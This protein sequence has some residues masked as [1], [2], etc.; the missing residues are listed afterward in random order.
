MLSD[1][2]KHHKNCY[3][4]ILNLLSID[5]GWHMSTSALKKKKR[6]KTIIFQP[7]YTCKIAHLACSPILD[8]LMNYTDHFLPI[9]WNTFLE[10]IF[11]GPRSQSVDQTG[12]ELAISF[13]LTSS[14]PLS[15]LSL[16]SGG[17]PGVCH[18][19]AGVNNVYASSACPVV[20]TAISFFA[21]F[22]INE[23]VRSLSDPFSH[24]SLAGPAEAPCHF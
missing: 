12:L 2:L 5:Q 21:I 7:V 14:C 9:L 18:R 20:S 10:F 15:Y 13:R 8:H 1:I 16:L 6:V 22:L 3:I 19:A 24:P 4:R 23:I 17:I 11:V